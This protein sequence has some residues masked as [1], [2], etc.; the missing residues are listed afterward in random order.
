MHIFA[1]TN[2]PQSSE[3]NRILR[4]RVHISA[5]YTIQRLYR[6][7]ENKAGFQNIPTAVHHFLQKRLQTTTKY[8]N[9]QLDT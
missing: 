5:G 8:G 4:S 9:A 6:A 7:A 1:M 3:Q 2:N